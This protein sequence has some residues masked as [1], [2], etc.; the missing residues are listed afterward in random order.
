MTSIT[1]SLATHILLLSCDSL[2]YLNPKAAFYF[3]KAYPI[4]LTDIM[5]ENCG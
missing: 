1:F 4:I 3:L 2:P 5:Q